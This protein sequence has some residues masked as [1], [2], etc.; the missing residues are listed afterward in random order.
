M[1]LTIILRVICYRCNSMNTID[2]FSM[3]NKEITS[4]NDGFRGVDFEGNTRVFITVS[5]V[6]LDYTPHP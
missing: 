3:Q 6:I 2:S 1:H 5:D 4:A